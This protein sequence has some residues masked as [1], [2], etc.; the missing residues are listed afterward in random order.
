MRS[1]F[2]KL[3]TNQGT[4]ILHATCTGMEKMAAAPDDAQTTRFSRSTVLKPLSVAFKSTSCVVVTVLLV[5]FA[6]QAILS[7][8]P[9][10]VCL[11][12]YL[13][14]ASWPPKYLIDFTNLTFYDL[15]GANFYIEGI[16]QCSID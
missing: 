13:N 1:R 12:M 5:G 9:W 11:M 6:L 16:V 7:F 3:N 10:A 4:K 8:Y 14:H 15:E 2:T